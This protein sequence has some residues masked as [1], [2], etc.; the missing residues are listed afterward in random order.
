MKTSP[1]AIIASAIALV[2][3]S[4]VSDKTVL[5]IILHA[6]YVEQI[7]VSY[8]D[9][10]TVLYAQD[11]L[12]TLELPV[13]VTDVVRVRVSDNMA[14]LISDGSRI[15]VDFTADPF[16]INSSAKSA[17]AA[18][19]AYNEAI[20][21]FRMKYSEKWKEVNEN[22]E[23]DDEAKKSQMQEFYEA[24]Y[25][26]FLENSKKVIKNNK[27]NATSVAALRVIYADMTAEEILGTIEGLSPKLQE[28]KFIVSLKEAVEAEAKTAE[29]Q[30]FSDFEVSYEGKTEKLS[31][32]VGQGKYILVD[33]WASWC[34]PCKQ[35]IPNLKEV[36]SK[37]HGDKFDILSVAV[38]DDPQASIDTA[39]VYQIPWNHMVNAQR[40]PTD[41]YGI[42]G[43][44]HII[45]FGPDGT[46]LKRNLRGEE[47]GNTVGKYVR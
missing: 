8:A 33:F 19:A 41:L 42:S 38:W 21:D 43:I 40:I 1:F 35:E 17:A 44:P 12:A 22:A 4:Q 11:G 20:N 32:Y 31:D 3:C 39:A 14:S 10:D 16:V 5:N 47:I 37:Y 18:Y 25:A 34:G 30:M 46:I 2:S 45:L 26:D 15:T 9:A 13:D 23:L 28:D 29:G 27:D 24:S 36:Y 6:D 7:R